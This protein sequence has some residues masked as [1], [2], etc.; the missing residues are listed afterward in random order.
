VRQIK[1]VWRRPDKVVPT[2][3]GTE[4]PTTVLSRAFPKLSFQ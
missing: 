2:A 3:D 1:Q 4:H